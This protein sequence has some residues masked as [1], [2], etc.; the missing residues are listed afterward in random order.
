[1]ISQ[2]IGPRQ[3]LEDLQIPVVYENEWVG[4]QSVSAF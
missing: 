3:T 2:G 1:M 4:K